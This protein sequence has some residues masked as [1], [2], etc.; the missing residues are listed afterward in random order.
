MKDAGT[1]AGGSAA[2]CGST[3]AASG[4]VSVA[5]CGACLAGQRFVEIE[6]R[7]HLSLVARFAGQR[8]WFVADSRCGGAASRT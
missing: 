2:G 7:L 1:A 4:A 6:A 5:V 3:A 8:G